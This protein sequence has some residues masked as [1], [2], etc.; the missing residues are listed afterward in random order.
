MKT[1][2]LV[3]FTAKKYF[4]FNGLHRWDNVLGVIQQE[5]KKAILI[6]PHIV[7]SWCSES[8]WIPKSSIKI[9]KIGIIKNIHDNWKNDKF[10]LEEVNKFIKQSKK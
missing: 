1:R 10:V 7:S 6:Q 8:Y 4:K 9:L 2:P 3:K 5:T